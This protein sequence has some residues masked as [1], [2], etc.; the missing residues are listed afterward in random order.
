MYYVYLLKSLM[1]GKGYIGS[2]TDL[3]R[4]VAEHKAGRVVSTKPRLPIQLIYYEAYSSEHDAR[5]R[6]ASLKLKSRAYIQLRKRLS[7]TLK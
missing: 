1:D 6:E 3:R 2:T 4:R 7:D 5:Q